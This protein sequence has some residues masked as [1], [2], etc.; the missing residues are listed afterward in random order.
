MAI[1]FNI[2]KTLEIL[3][4]IKV[5]Y[6]VLFLS[7]ISS[8]NLWFLC[9]YFF[10]PDFISIYGIY[11]TLMVAFSLSVAWC[12]LCGI[13]V[14]KSIIL[15]CLSADIKEIDEVLENKSLINV[16]IFS[17]IILMHSL[18][19]YLTYLFHWSFFVFVT[20]SFFVSIVIYFV[21][22]ILTRLEFEKSYNK[23][24]KSNQPSNQ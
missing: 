7:F 15:Y 12:L 20:V 19:A 3:S 6:F 11:I 13:T 16:F 9:I 1:K 18:F 21:V 23:G 22:D 17:E 8:F 14:P 10:K 24:Q 4:K 2:H 5:E